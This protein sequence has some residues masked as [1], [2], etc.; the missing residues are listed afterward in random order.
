MG[1]AAMN[2]LLKEY[3]ET[4]LEAGKGD[5][6][7]AF[8]LRNIL[9]VGRGGYVAMITI[10]NW[11]F[12][13]TFET[14]RSTLLLEA[15][16][17]S[18]VHVGRGVWGSDFGS[19]AFVIHTGG[20]G[21]QVGYFKRL[22]KKAGEV[23]PNEE[24]ERNFFD[25]TNFPIYRAETGHF[26]LIPGCPIAYWTT[27]RVREI[28]AESSP[29]SEVAAPRKGLTTADNDRFLRLWH[30]I[31]DC[32]MEKKAASDV[33]QLKSA[34]K[35][36]PV[37]KGGNFRKW[38]GNKDFVVNWEENGAE[39]ARFS[40][41]VIRNP[42][43]YFREGMTW[44]DI[45]IGTLAM[46]YSTG[47]SMFEG[48]GPMAFASNTFELMNLI[49]LFNSKVGTSFLA[50]LCPTLNFNIGEIAKI[51]VLAGVL[52]DE[53]IQRYVVQM[54]GL[55]RADWNNFETSWDFCDQPLLRPELKGATLE[56]SWQSWEAQSTAAI[57]RMQE[58][59]T[60]NNR[61]FIAAYGLDGELQPEVPEEQITLARADARRDMAAFLSYAVGCMMGRYS[62]DRAGLIYADGG[63]QNFWDTYHEKHERHEKNINGVFSCDSCLSW[64][65]FP[66]DPDGILP[67]LET[68]WGIHDDVTN[69]LIE[70]IN[71]AWPGNLTTDFTDDTDGNKY[72]KSKTSS[73]E[74]S[75]K[76]VVKS[77]PVLNENI[78]FLEDSL[79]STIREY[80]ASGFYKTHLQ[81]YKK[82]PIYW[83]FSSGKQKAFQC[84]VYLH[85]YNE[86]TLARM[87]TEYVI[88][89]QGKF[90]ARLEQLK[91]DIA[92]STSTAQR[93]KLEKEFDKINKQRTELQSFDEKL[94]HYADL[95]IKLDLDDGVKVNYGKFSDPE[96]GDILADVK[97]I[98]GTKDEE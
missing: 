72:E 21:L 54:I 78:K 38:Y 86:G 81:T 83:L 67:I 20:V 13:K 53:K 56:A 26:K 14:L 66:P 90:A 1:A 68:D 25:N 5:T 59:E 64:S 62:L 60:E 76:S 32:R 37:N 33:G 93:K 2:P 28:F 16:I 11:M 96:F 77:S 30:E 70:F 23:Q 82:R 12:L 34:K 8:I 42:T 40:N 9:L 89:L 49:G 52:K 85:R 95:R 15:F 55:A 75:V 4:H 29:F 65:S 61:L 87:R 50:F 46:R 63:N 80:L 73:S 79:G 97:A 22:F 92:K 39:I 27:R 84:L 18:L 44:N 7:A 17:S 48:K 69:R 45:S 3:V 94:R 71:V 6:Y 47:D 98:C 88:P 36:F 58:L 31:A 35:W 41:S 24:L 51:P 19:C 57:R 43:F 10:P 91:D 74:K